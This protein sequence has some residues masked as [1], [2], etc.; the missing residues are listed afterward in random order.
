MLIAKLYTVI[1][2]LQCVCSLYV[3]LIMLLITVHY[4][5]NILEIIKVRLNLEKL[6]AIK[7]NKKKFLPFFFTLS[8]NFFI[9]LV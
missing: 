3:R 5:F 6:F 7:G 9:L 1:I 8:Y 4:I 2:R